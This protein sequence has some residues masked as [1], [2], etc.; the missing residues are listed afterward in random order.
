MARDVSKVV[1]G[2]R[3]RGRAREAKVFYHK[4]QSK[5]MPTAKVAPVM[6]HT[7]THAPYSSFEQQT[8]DRLRGRWWRHVVCRL[9]A[10]SL[11]RSLSLTPQRAVRSYQ[12][13]GILLVVKKDCQA[14]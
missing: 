2:W 8:R 3:A 13:V 7:L 4:G 12:V 1:R 11:A 14:R 5:P 9:G 10:R 6:V